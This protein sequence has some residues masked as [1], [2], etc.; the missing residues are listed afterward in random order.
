[1]LVD[2]AEICKN[3]PSE[4]QQCLQYVKSLKFEDVPDYDH[5]LKLVQAGAHSAGVVLDNEFEWRDSLTPRSNYQLTPR[6]NETGGRGQ[7][8]YNTHLFLLPPGSK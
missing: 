5:I 1:M 6:N 7:Q 8:K 2:E 4:I 3:M